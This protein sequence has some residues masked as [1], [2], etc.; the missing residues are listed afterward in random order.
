MTRGSWVARSGAG[1]AGGGVVEW[2]ADGEVAGGVVECSVRCSLQ[3]AVEECRGWGGSCV[4]LPGRGS[5]RPPSEV[6]TSC[7]VVEKIDTGRKVN[8]CDS[9]L[10]VI[11][12]SPLSLCIE[13]S[14]VGAP[15]WQR[16]SSPSR[17]VLVA[18]LHCLALGGEG[19]GCLAG[20]RKQQTGARMPPDAWC[21]RS[22]KSN[23]NTPEKGTAC[24]SRWL[25][26]F[27]SFPDTARARVGNNKKQGTCA[28]L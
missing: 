28:Y 24:I 15:R 20:F 14:S 6:N 10:C 16:R 3:T 12:I 9:A 5:P 17:D 25:H 18:C 27:N 4:T 22:P 26:F 1:V 19:G 21:W 2:R 13:A 23:N 8:T 7:L 11:P